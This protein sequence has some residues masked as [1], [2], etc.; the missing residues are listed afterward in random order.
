MRNDI[1]RRVN[2]E[3]A[4]LQK[5]V[6]AASKHV[7]AINLLKEAGKW[8]TLPDSLK[9]IGELRINNQGASLKE[10]GELMN[11]RIGKSGV[12]H[13]LN[14]LLEAAEEIQFI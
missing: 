10:L 4:N 13:R 12:N 5:S 6:K 14:R 7:R 1:N 11:P 2:F 9:E 3:S 8:E